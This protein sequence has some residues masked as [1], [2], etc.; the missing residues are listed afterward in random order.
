MTGR[1]IH[2]YIDYEI[3]DDISE[4]QTLLSDSNLRFPL[5]D[6]RC[7]KIHAFQMLRWI[8]EALLRSVDVIGKPDAMF[9]YASTSHI[10]S[11]VQL[12]PGPSCLGP[13]RLWQRFYIFVVICIMMRKAAGM[14]GRFVCRG[15]VLKR[16]C[17]Y[18][19]YIPII[20]A[21][22]IR[23]TTI[24]VAHVSSHPKT[25]CPKTEDCMHVNH[26]FTYIQHYC[27]ISFPCNVLQ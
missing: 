21:V 20:V 10:E 19:G 12:P 23:I 17:I 27:D 11:C 6:Q 2:L 14:G 8:W 4:S 3:S 24:S 13:G 18:I 22:C 1:E 26:E 9:C 15:R 5:F 16:V 7:D 25:V